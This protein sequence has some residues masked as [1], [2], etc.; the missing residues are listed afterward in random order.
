MGFEIQRHPTHHQADNRWRITDGLIDYKSTMHVMH[1]G[2][3]HTWFRSHNSTVLL[4]FSKGTFSNLNVCANFLSRRRKHHLQ[5]KEFYR[6]PLPF[7]H[8][9]SWHYHWRRHNSGSILSLLFF[10]FDFSLSHFI[11]FLTFPPSSY[12]F[13][14]TT[15]RLIRQISYPLA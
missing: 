6:R 1:R 11:Q 12:R 5:I 15:S 2:R 4:N 9:S 10:C 7:N 8:P 3:S 13:S 14:P